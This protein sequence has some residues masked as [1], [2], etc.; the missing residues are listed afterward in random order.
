MYVAFIGMSPIS[1]KFYGSKAFAYSLDGNET[2]PSIMIKTTRE[3]AAG[4]LPHED[5]DETRIISKGQIDQEGN[6]VPF[7]DGKLGGCY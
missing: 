4:F 5:F 2:R 1:K 3:N 7:T 6:Y